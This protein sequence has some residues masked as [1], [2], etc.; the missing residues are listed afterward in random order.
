MK[1]SNT[2]IGKGANS[3]SKNC[4]SGV[5]RF[6]NPFSCRLIAAVLGLIAILGCSKL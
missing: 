3:M 5:F 1:I 4:L 2:A 6:Q